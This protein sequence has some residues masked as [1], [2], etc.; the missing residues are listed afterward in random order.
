MKR[1]ASEA[2]PRTVR[3]SPVLAVAAM[4]AV[5]CAVALWPA[6]LH[7]ADSVPHSVT[8]DS[9]VPLEMADGDHLQLIYHFELL[10]DYLRG[11]APWFSDIWEFNTS[12][13]DRPPRP[14]G[15]YAPFAL[16]YVVLRVLGAPDAFA[17]NMVVLLSAVLGAILC[18]ALAFRHG[19]GRCGAFLAAA[20]AGSVP[21][22]W[23]A[24]AAGS[25]TG[26]GM[27]L[28]PAVALGLDIALRDGKARGGLLAGAALVLLWMSDLHCFFFAAL[29]VPLWMAVSLVLEPRP[30]GAC[31]ERPGPAGLFRA[32][33]P[34]A[35][36][37]VL[38]AL[39]AWWTG[40]AYTG[41]N[42]ETGRT[43]DAVL[44]HSPEWSVL[45]RPAPLDF[46]SGQFHVG[47]ALPLLASVAALVFA[48]H[49]L[50]R[51][52]RALAGLVLAAAIVFSFTVA[53]GTNGPFDGLPIRAMRACI[54][55]FRM[56]RQPLKIL[57]L[58]PSFSAT[59]FGLCFAILRRKTRTWNGPW[60]W[61]ATSAVAVAVAFDA[62][63]GTVVG[64]CRLP[65]EN[66]AYAAAADAARAR[67]STPRALVLPIY[68]GDNYFNAPYLYWA[69][70]SR[71]RML[72]GYAATWSQ[73]YEDTVAK[74]Y[75]TMAE[76]D[77]SDDQL[78]GL[79]ACGVNSVLVHESL[80]ARSRL[81]F[82]GGATLRRMLANPHLRFLACNRGVWAFELLPEGG[83]PEPVPFSPTV[84]PAMHHRRFDPPFPG[85][86]AKVLSAAEVH[87]EGYGWL[88]RAEADKEL[89]LVVSRRRENEILSAVTN[90]FPP[91]PSGGTGSGWRLAF[92]PAPAGDG[93]LVALRCTGPA[94]VSDALFTSAAATGGLR[95]I[96]FADL[97]HRHGETFLNGGGRPAGVRFVPGRA[98]AGMTVSGPFLPLSADGTKVRLA[99]FDAS[100]ILPDGTDAGPPE[101][102]VLVRPDGTKVPLRV[103]DALP[104]DGTEPVS[105]EM[106]FDPGDGVTLELRELTFAD[107]L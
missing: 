65:G 82:P 47:Y 86:R 48:R 99:G 9:S 61:L 83:S 24:L 44:R 11:R 97:P 27:G 77:F 16:P 102:I 66:A 32:L 38:A 18:F 75:R 43:F 15:C 74:R 35:A 88:V 63:C 6:P 90:R 95:R 34:F 107:A 69:R 72:N 79:R 62:R 64:V 68:R 41:T 85:V 29:A 2:G 94:A 5:L 93:P 4:G 60:A 42:V 36:C 91:L 46:L 49:A 31:G 28:V 59:M 51:D 56:I 26:F 8:A 57:C 7:F 40:R 22:R 10:G 30:G 98:P 52:H 50:A 105:F 92:C 1:P 106:P 25:P 13:A 37:C 58:L 87:R 39:A 3:R 73:A 81:P 19:A 84:E 70:I 78:A 96:C 80:L 67:G 71:L 103:G 76:G 14:D 45:F 53:V 12:D 89:A 54:P 17:Y 33:A 55:H 20:L 104:G 21:Y 101:T 100:R 23:A